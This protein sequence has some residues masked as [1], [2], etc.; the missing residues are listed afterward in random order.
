M[1]TTLESSVAGD[2]KLVS[3]RID[4]LLSEHDP[5]QTDLTTFLGIGTAAQTQA[6]CDQHPAYKH[7]FAIDGGDIQVRGN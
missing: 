1:S 2:E 4:Q 5:K 3:E 7:P 6:F